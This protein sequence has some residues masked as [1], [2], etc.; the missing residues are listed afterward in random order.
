M[1]FDGVGS[2]AC[3]AVIEVEEGDSGNDGSRTQADGGTGRCH[4]AAA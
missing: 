2:Y 4:L 3:L 1:E